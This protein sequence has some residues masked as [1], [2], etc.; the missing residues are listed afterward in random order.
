[1]G[2]PSWSHVSTLIEPTTQL[3]PEHLP[4]PMTQHSFDET[5]LPENSDGCIPPMRGSRF[6]PLATNGVVTSSLS[7]CALVA[8][9]GPA[10]SN[11]TDRASQNRMRTPSGRRM[12]IKGALMRRRAA[13]GVAGSLVAGALLL[14]GCAP[15]SEPEP[16]ATSAESP[17][18][19]MTVEDLEP[20]NQTVEHDPAV[21]DEN[22]D[23]LLASLQ[24]DSSLTVEEKA[25]AFMDIY[26]RWAMVGATPESVLEER[27][28]TIDAVEP[29]G[30][31]F[32][33]A[34]AEQNAEVFAI[35]MFGENWSK[36]SDVVNEWEQVN[37]SD[38]DRYLST[39][40]SEAIPNTNSKNVE[41][42]T[43]SFSENVTV[44]GWANATEQS[45]PSLW[46]L[47]ERA[48]KTYGTDNLLIITLTA[49]RSNNA[50]HNM[51]S[52][53][54]TYAEANGKTM[55]VHVVL[56]PE[57]GHDVVRYIQIDDFDFGNAVSY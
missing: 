43:E 15:S 52:E 35:A 34:V 14:A 9:A 22:R 55:Y 11:A 20:T 8:L 57:N 13:V 50:E 29:Q 12:R 54:A 2:S 23:E 40:G 27:Q 21:T 1:M 17:L 45:H 30:E 7:R 18:A 3:F 51:F 36:H 46:P 44:T 39:F 56:T 37:A 4:W 6:A 16:T 24:I 25:S 32:A 49:Q 38:I 47:V 19:S 41:A 28:N 10:F 31:D 42:F 33:K 48:K 53:N 5:T 26:T